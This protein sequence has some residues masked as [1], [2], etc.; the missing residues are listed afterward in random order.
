M[1]IYTYMLLSRLFLTCQNSTAKNLYP[2]L[3]HHNPYRFLA[4]SRRSRDVI[5]VS[6][7]NNTSGQTTHLGGQTDKLSSCRIRGW[8]AAS[9]AVLPGDDI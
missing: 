6:V 3:T 4:A 8:S 5:L 9:A 2:I 1:C 7:K